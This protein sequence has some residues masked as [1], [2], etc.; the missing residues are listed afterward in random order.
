MRDARMTWSSTRC[1]TTGLLLS[2][3]VAAFPVAARAQT[4]SKILPATVCQVWGPFENNLSAAVVSDIRN[5]IRYTHNGRIE[6]WHPTYKIGVVCPLVRDTVASRLDWLTVTFRDN[7]PGTGA[8]NRGRLDCTLLANNREGTAAVAS[9]YEDSEGENGDSPDN[10]GVF[11]F[12]NMTLDDAATDGSYT[13]FCG[14][15]PTYH[16]LRSFIGSMRYQEP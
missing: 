2:V 14:I 4:D 10:D 7:Y 13:L 9:H 12:E 6:N 11:D 15:P 3:M 8:S 16:G 1:H 5:S